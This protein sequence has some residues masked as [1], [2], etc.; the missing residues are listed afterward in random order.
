MK[1]E[2]ALVDSKYEYNESGRDEGS[3]QDEGET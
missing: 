2:E 3:K 1:M